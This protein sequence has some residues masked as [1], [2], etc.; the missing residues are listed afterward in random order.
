MA[1]GGVLGGIAGAHGACVPAPGAEADEG[2]VALRGLG[3]APEGGG[4][5][6]L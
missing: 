4:L 5:R 2:A 6:R 1:L 3:G